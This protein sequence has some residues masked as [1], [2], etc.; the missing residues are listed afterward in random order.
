M[1]RLREATRITYDESKLE[2]HIKDLN[3]S[4]EELR[5]L[6]EQTQELRKPVAT[7]PRRTI[8]MQTDPEYNHFRKTKEASKALHEAFTTV[9]SNNGGH[10][11]SPEMQHIVRL[12]LHTNVEE[13]VNM[14][15]AITCDGHGM[16]TRYAS[17]LLCIQLG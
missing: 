12:F 5:K 10:G 7:A 6:R 2:A 4:I 15:A 17:L 16:G 3:Q 14:N 9:W 13:D 1:R 8:R 11:M